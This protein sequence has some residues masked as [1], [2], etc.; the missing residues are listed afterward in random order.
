MI[1]DYKREAVFT[2][3]FDIVDIGNFTIRATSDDM[4]DYFVIVKTVMGTT[5]IIKF[6]PC[7]P[8]LGTLCDDYIMTYTNCDF[9]EKTI[10]REVSSFIND[11]KKKI[12]NV[13]E[14]TEY[15]ALACLPD[16][17]RTLEE[18]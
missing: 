4:F 15:E 5:G 13:V 11:S 9:K 8:D 7:L 10:C 17:T 6:G 3:S 16:I 14:L 18:M 12:S 1:F 2:K